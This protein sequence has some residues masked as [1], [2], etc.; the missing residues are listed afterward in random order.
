MSSPGSPPTAAAV[1]GAALS[2]PPAR[3]GGPAAAPRAPPVPGV[4][5][6]PRL[7]PLKIT[8]M[9]RVYVPRDAVRSMLPE[10]EAAIARAKQAAASEPDGQGRVHT[11][12]SI[13][14][15]ATGRAWP[16]TLTTSVRLHGSAVNSE[17]QAGCRDMVPSL[18]GRVG[19]TLTLWRD[20]RPPARPGELVLRARV[21]A[22]GAG[23]PSPTA[24][25]T[26]AA[27]QATAAAPATGGAAASAAAVRAPTPAVHPSALEAGPRRFAVKVNDAHRAY[28]PR[29]A[30][31][32][33]L[34]EVEAAIPRARQ[35]A[36]SKRKKRGRI[37]AQLTIVDDVTGRAWPVTLTTQ[38]HVRTAWVSSELIDGCR[39][40]AAGLGGGVGSTLTLWRDPRPPVRP[41]ELVLRVRVEAG[42]A[43]GPSPTALR[44][45]TAHQATASAPATGGAAAGAAAVGA[46]APAPA[47]DLATLFQCLGAALTV[48]AAQA[49]WQ[50]QQGEGQ[51][52]QQEEEEEEEE[53]QWP[54]VE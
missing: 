35:A 42:G 53:P 7:F 32:S 1:G 13:V 21:E 54:P 38:A 10:V 16:V 9:F 51:E 33:M 20:P 36:A 18:G 24:L 31:R 50:R 22:G 26:S 11:Q 41:G 12:L 45:S 3:A 19:S 28:V 15:D 37:H 52:P 25:R 2:L 47:V 29:D 4:E 48:N 39:D 17:L 43:G 30:V 46:P 5:A 40:M 44:T 6:G 23:G 34:P 27:H 8:E 49:A 14:D